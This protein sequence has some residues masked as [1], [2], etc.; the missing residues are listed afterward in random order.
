MFF[1]LCFKQHYSKDG[2]K[3]KKGLKMDLKINI[4]TDRKDL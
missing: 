3:K 1:F 4:P 2:S